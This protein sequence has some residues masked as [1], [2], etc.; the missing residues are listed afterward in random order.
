[1]TE[2][3]TTNRGYKFKRTN[4]M[5]GEFGTKLNKEVNERLT[6]FCRAK[7]LNKTKYVN[8]I[9]MER[10]DQDLNELYN[11]MSK[12]ELIRYLTDRRKL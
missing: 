6:E 8:Q 3:K 9:V 1:M 10:L 7:N 11:S 12:E 2:K 4:N 5:T